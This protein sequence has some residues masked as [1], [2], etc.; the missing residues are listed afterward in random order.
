MSPALLFGFDRLV[1]LHAERLPMRR[2]ARGTAV[3]THKITMISFSNDTHG[4]PLLFFWC[5]CCPLVAFTL[6]SLFFL[7]LESVEK[8]CIG[9]RQGRFV[10]VW[11]ATTYGPDAC[12]D[13]LTTDEFCRCAWLFVSPSDGY[14]YQTVIRTYNIH[15]RAMMVRFMLHCFSCCVFSV[16]GPSQ[17]TLLQ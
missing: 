17:R 12:L 11:A 7:A 8:K 15:S 3:C 4:Y 2:C 16:F 6:G 5:S 9:N 14:R 13:A 10:N 1:L